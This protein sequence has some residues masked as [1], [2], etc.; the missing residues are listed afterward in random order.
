MELKLLDDG[1]TLNTVD[2][3]LHDVYMW[4]VD[5]LAEL[6]ERNNESLCLWQ[7]LLV[8]LLSVDVTWNKSLLAKCFCGLLANGSALLTVYGNFSH[9]CLCYSKIKLNNFALIHHHTNALLRKKRCKGMEKC[10]NEKIME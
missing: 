7:T 3:Q 10:K 8:T 6:C 5:D 9:N 1:C 4:S 2:V